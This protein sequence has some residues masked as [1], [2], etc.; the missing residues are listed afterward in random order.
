MVT[1]VVGG[2]TVQTSTT[3]FTNIDLGD[4][5]KC[6]DGSIYKM[7]GNVSTVELTLTDLQVQVFN[8]SK[9]KEFGEGLQCFYHCVSVLYLLYL[10]KEC[11]N[12]P[13]HIDLFESCMHVAVVVHNISITHPNVGQ[14]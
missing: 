6:I 11:S 7:T 1:I 5:Y 3:G 13:F 8:F 12:L 4:S 10:A 14:V 9:P 2:D